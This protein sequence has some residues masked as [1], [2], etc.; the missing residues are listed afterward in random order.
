MFRELKRANTAFENDAR[1]PV[2]GIFRLCNA[3]KLVILSR[4]APGD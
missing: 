2:A 1:A 3:G 4:N